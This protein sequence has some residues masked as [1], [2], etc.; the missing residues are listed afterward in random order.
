MCFV[1]PV[2]ST[3][4]KSPLKVFL[5]DFSSD[6]ITVCSW[7]SACVCLVDKT[8]GNWKFLLAIPQSHFFFF[9]F[10]KILLKINLLKWGTHLTGPW[11]TP[12]AGFAHVCL[13][14]LH[15][16]IKQHWEPGGYVWLAATVKHSQ[17]E[18]GEEKK[19][20][21]RPGSAVQMG[22]WHQHG[23]ETEDFCF[24]W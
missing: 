9:S 8:T 20:P 15:P 17:C 19:P 2:F 7:C 22:K 11:R 14:I 24:A 6:I 16:F 21:K 5:S 1:M 10:F 13:L 18:K 12:G 4:E 23:G 3:R